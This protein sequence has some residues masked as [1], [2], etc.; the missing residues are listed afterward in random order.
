MTA[1]LITAEPDAWDGTVDALVAGSGGAGL[2]AALFAADHGLHVLVVEKTPLV[3]GT[4]GVSGGTVWIANNPHV[5]DAGV[6][7]SPA[8][9]AA[10]MRAVSAGTID[11]DVLATLVDD[12]PRLIT[13]LAAAGVAF[14]PFPSV[15]PT[16]DYRFRLPGAKHGGRSL[17]PVAFDLG[18]L[19]P[20][21]DRIRQGT[22]AG[23]VT[24]KKSYYRNRAYLVRPQDRPP[25]AELPSG[26]VGAGSAL[27]GHLLRAC[28]DRGV[29]VRVEVSVEALVVVDGSVR[30]V[31]LSTPDGPRTMRVRAGTVLATGG[32]E[33]NEEL[34]KRLLGRPLTHPVSAPVADGDGLLLGLAAGAD[35]RGLGDAWWTPAIDL[36]GAE[37]PR[38]GGTRNMMCRV[39]RGLPHAIIVN[40]AG[41]RFVNEATN[42]YDLPEAFGSFAAGVPNLPAWLVIDQQ[43]RDRYPLVGTASDGVAEPD[44]AWLTQ[45][46]TLEDLAERCGIDVAGLAA[47]VKAFN[48]YAAAGVDPEFG[49]GA[50]SWDR[51]WG[52]PAHGPNP[53]L[54]AIERGPFYAV[55]LHAGALG[56]K[57][58]LR[59]DGRG[60]VVSAATGEAMPG[61]YAVGNVAAGSV[62][63]GYV[64]PGATLGP[65]MTFGMVA[66]DHLA[67]RV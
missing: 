26:V 36:G 49:R 2:T 52:D 21:A 15:G 22:T 38:G 35:V 14:E 48:G 33:W 9:A 51:E 6:V 61:L 60:A 56:T 65:G 42:Y 64:G 1:R 7:D 39:E 3:G 66:A 50:S 29:E 40:R 8:D 59:V 24:D 67:A 30:G 27:I 57:G 47:T 16:L 41:R 43:F 55:E 63:W 23:W 18:R 32:F 37:S 31:R 46:D 17:T 54:G 45:A 44:P 20:W 12:G 62:P 25:V 5:T 34:K 11:D 58:G 19:G 13:R 53:S 28:L 4:T 10:Y